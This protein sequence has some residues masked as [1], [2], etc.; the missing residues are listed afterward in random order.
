M[1]VVKRAIDSLRGSIEIQSVRGQ[2]AT[3]IIKLPLTLAIIDGLQVKVGGGYYVIPLSIVEEC[4]ELTRQ[5]V[6]QANE[7]HIIHLRGEIVPYIRLREW[8]ELH[9]DAPEIEQIVITGVEGSRVGIVVDTVI[10]EH[11]TVIKSLGRV[12]R[13][14][15]GISGATI[16]GDGTMALILDIPRLFRSVLGAKS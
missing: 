4:V 14:V 11:Q 13:D 10:G 7:Q 9:G 15:E 12:Y 6:A 5:D 3:I 1:D 16:K 2:G 8:F